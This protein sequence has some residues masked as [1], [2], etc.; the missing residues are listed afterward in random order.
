[1]QAF[2]LKEVSEG[3]SDQNISRSPFYLANSAG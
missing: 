3:N 2:D 1:M